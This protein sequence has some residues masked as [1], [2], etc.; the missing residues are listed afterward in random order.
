[1]D[2]RLSNPAVNAIFAS[3]SR[4]WPLG[5]YCHDSVR[6]ESG[7]TAVFSDVTSAVLVFLWC[8]IVKPRSHR[9]ERYITSM[10]YSGPYLLIQYNNVTDICWNVND[11]PVLCT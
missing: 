5:R 11:K 8:F 2:L 3:R 4:S 9:D 1:M 7:P 10:M 6:T